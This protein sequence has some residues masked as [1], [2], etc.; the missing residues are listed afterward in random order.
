MTDD[1]RDTQ[2]SNGAA[3]HRAS[4]DATPT[5]PESERLVSLEARKRE[6]KVA[7][8]DPDVRGWDVRTSDDVLIGKVDD[9]I[10]DIDMMKVRYLTVKIDRHLIGVAE[11]R[12]V[13]VPIGEA[14]VDDVKSDVWVDLDAARLVSLPAY[15]TS[16]FDREYEDAVRDCFARPEPDDATARAATSDYYSGNRFDDTRFFGSR[17]KGEQQ[18]EETTL[19]QEETL[20]EKRVESTGD[21]VVET[22]FVH[23]ER[24][25]AADASTA[26]IQ[27]DPS[28]T[29]RSA[30]RE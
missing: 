9:L 19:V 17:R 26:T 3:D 10:V 6:F 12:H 2:S 27:L 7:D 28:G 25:V 23:E 21:E 8:D 30:D 29:R 13:L 22:R 18:E 20:V 16:L 24:T 11:N 4:D 1:L 5:R 15:E 14:R